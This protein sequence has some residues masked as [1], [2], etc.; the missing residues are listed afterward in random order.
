MPIYKMSMEEIRW[1]A[2][3]PGIEASNSILQCKFPPFRAK[4]VHPSVKVHNILA[5][6][7][8]QFQ[9]EEPG[10]YEPGST[11]LQHV[12]PDTSPLHP[13][14][15]LLKSLRLPYP[16]PSGQRKQTRGSF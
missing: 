13:R 16:I 6:S 1:K 5:G 12:S 9:R 3:F 8:Q 2:A 10:C 4:S 14:L 7:P 15:K 11:A